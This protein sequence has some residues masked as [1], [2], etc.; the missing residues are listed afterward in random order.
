MAIF[1]SLGTVALG[2]TNRADV[3]F[4]ISKAQ[5]LIN[6][7]A[8][9]SLVDAE[10][11]VYSSGTCYSLV[12]DTTISNQVVTGQANVVV[13]ETL[14]LNVDT[15]TYQILWQLVG[16]DFETTVAEQVKVVGLEASQLGAKDAVELYGTVASLELVLPYAH[17][18]VGYQVFFGNYPHSSTQTPVSVVAS[19]QAVSDGFRYTAQFDTSTM[20]SPG[21]M[22]E[23]YTI[24]WSYA[25]AGGLTYKETARF[26]VVTPS[27]LLATRDIQ[28]VVNK[29]KTTVEGVPDAAYSLDELLNYLKIGMDNFNAYAD[30]TAF[31]MTNATGV[32]R[33]YWVQFSE[34]VAL[35]SQYLVEG[36]KAFNFSGQSVTLD[37]DRSQYY[38]SLASSIE[39]PLH[40]ATRNLKK[41]LSKRGVTG[42]DGSQDPRAL[43]YG[44]IGAVGISLSP[45]S[46]VRTY[47]TGNAG[48]WWGLGRVV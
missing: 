5:P 3:S 45:V 47:G 7:V 48:S 28:S 46:N 25:N 21:A 19:E 30:P 24:V 22:L 26:Y 27:I 35:R 23:P 36:T 44:S 9:W 34:I 4:V 10:G 29:A 1:S 43:G 15:T 14:S 2:S 8:T 39:G 11:V 38:E 41:L 33:S 37:V 16:T 40:E 42:G 13:P 32:I 31:T 17:S 20:T 18:V 12:I 6:P